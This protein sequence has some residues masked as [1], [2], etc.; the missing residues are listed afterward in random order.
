[1]SQSTWKWIDDLDR[2]AVEEHIRLT[3]EQSDR[4]RL[5]MIDLQDRYRQLTYRLNR[6]RR[7]AGE[8]K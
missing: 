8:I 6:L 5:E 3:A 4:L 7:E 2:A 1:M